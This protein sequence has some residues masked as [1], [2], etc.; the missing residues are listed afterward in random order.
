MRPGSFFHKEE[1]GLKSR[2]RQTVHPVAGAGHK[3]CHKVGVTGWTPNCYM[4]DALAAQ[5]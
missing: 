2:E 5:T 3:V 4:G 1:D